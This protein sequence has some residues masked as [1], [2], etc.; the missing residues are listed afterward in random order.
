VSDDVVDTLLS[1][2][3]RPDLSGEERHVTVLFSDIRNFTTISEK[4][5]AHEVVEMLNAYFS[6]VCEPILQRGG[7]VNKYIG[8]AVMAVFGAPK[9]YA[10]HPRRALAAAVDMVE[11]GKAFRTWM[12]ARFPDRGLPD[13]AIGVGLHTGSCVVGTS[14]LRSA[15]SSRPSATWSTPP[16]GW[17]ASPRNSASGSWPAPPPSRRRAL[18]C[19]RA[20]ARPCT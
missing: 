17:K 15:R 7:M 20:S 10:D 14:A 16:R 4:L 3:D 1:D 11:V 12:N 18:A 9:F 5:S 19:R 2:A 6:L 8:D 13:F